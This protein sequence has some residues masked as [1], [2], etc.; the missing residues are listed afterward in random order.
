MRFEWVYVQ[1]T[2]QKI[3]YFLK[4]LGISKSLLAKIKFRGGNIAVNNRTVN[5][6]YKLK[7]Q[8]LLRIDIPAE[9]ASETLL[10]DEAE[11]NIVY[12]DQH[13][14]LVNKPDGMPSIPARFYPNGTVA[15]C[16]K[17]YFV[18]RNYENQQVHIVTRLDKNTT[19][20]MLL[21]KHG[22][23]HALLDKQLCE[24]KVFKHYYALV[25]GKLANLQKSGE[26]IEPIA[27]DL[28]S[29]LK[30]KVAPDGK[31]A[32]TIYCVQKRSKK[33]ALLDIQLKTG[34][35]HQIRVHFSSLG[36][37]LI[38]DE[39]YCGNLSFG[40]S[41]QALH[42]YR[43]EFFHPFLK[44]KME[45]TQNLPDDLQV[46]VERLNKSTSSKEIDKNNYYE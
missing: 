7:K 5:V 44:Q 26:I 41:R 31:L 28:T 8:D 23:A 40:I 24:K 19:G 35:T 30:R 13:F 15:N 6:L 2:P 20:L 34:R 33:L 42:C 22:F 36:C 12:E 9:K 18:Q 3:K 46:L 25:S 27:R 10:I 43:L 1:E 16:V 45:F 29:I 37:P 39:L 11:L 14:L 32:H 4:K 38:G 17:N 21:A